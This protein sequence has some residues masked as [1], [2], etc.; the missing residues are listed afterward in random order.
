MFVPPR[1]NPEQTGRDRRSS[2]QTRRRLR[3]RANPMQATIT[4]KPYEGMELSPEQYEHLILGDPDE[5]WELVNGR[6]REKPLMS[7]GHGD[8]GFELAFALR[9]QLDRRVFRV[10]HNHAR[11]KRTERSY[12]VPDVVVTRVADFTGDPSNPRTVDAHAAPA[13]LVVEIW[14]PSTGDYD[15]EE[16]LP[17]YRAR[18][19]LEIWRLHPF[20]HTLTAWRRQ[21]DGTYAESV[22]HGG[23]ITPG[24]LPAVTI[25]LDTLFI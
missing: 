17:E 10:S 24:E 11:L 1:Y 8:A 23:T 6:L 7:M 4:A 12:F 16:K 19:D 2:R 15:I 3:E 13:L 18:G 14:S 22:H 20:E 5:T 9:N 21:P 25:D